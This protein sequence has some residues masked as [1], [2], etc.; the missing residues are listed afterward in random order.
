MFS[1][2]C[3]LLKIYIAVS[4]PLVAILME[5]DGRKPKTLQ[6]DQENKY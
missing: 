1:Y 6:T 5:V 3:L 2:D 4:E